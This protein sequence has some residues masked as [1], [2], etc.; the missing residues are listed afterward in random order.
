MR[1]GKT[2]IVFI[3]FLNIVAILAIRSICFSDAGDVDNS[4]DDHNTAK[5]MLSQPTPVMGPLKVHPSNPRYFIDGS[6]K[7][8]YLTGS[9]MGC[10]L[11]DIGTTDPPLPF[12]YSGYLDFLREHNHN[13]IRMWTWELTKYTYPSFDGMLRYTEPFPWPRTGPGMALDGKPKFDLSQF[14]QEYFDRL[15]ARVVA[16]RDRGIYVA[17]M[18]FEGH[19]PQFSDPPWRWDGHP[20]NVSNNTN[21]IDGDPNGDG[22]GLEIHTLEI[23]GITALQET[24]VRKVVDTVNDLDN[25]LY[26][27]S[28]ETGPYST[29]WQYHMINYVKNYEAN[30]PNQHPVGMTFQYKGG[31]N[32]AL[33]SSPADWISPKESRSEPYRTD[34]PAADGSKVIILDTDHLWGIGGNRKWVWKSFLRGMNPIY[35]DPYDSPNH[36]P[37]ESIRWNLGYTLHYANRMNLAAATPQGDLASSG[38]C[39]ANP[40]ADGAEYLVYLPDGGAVTVDLSASPGKLAVEWFNPST[41]EKKHERMTTGGAE[42]SFTAP[43]SGDAVLHIWDDPIFRFYGMLCRALQAGLSQLDKFFRMIRSMLR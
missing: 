36:A 6:G 8:V 30:K 23:P 7:A 9:H 28:N 1:L 24:Y 31:S 29:D 3:T 14:Y 39:L 41:G 16:A 20:F 15:R 19:G 2:R 42:R 38:Y 13:F 18:L 40:V 33:F 5:G 4:M 10:Y 21:G 43:F 32:D 34:P 27:I 25:V 35:L 37:D 22:K 11:K 17:I 12:D 26:E